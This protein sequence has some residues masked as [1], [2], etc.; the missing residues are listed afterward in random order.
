MK[1]IVFLL[2]L[3]AALSFTP[4]AYADTCLCVGGNGTS[5]SCGNGGVGAEFLKSYAISSDGYKGFLRDSTA[6][7]VYSRDGKAFDSKT[8][9]FCWKG[10]LP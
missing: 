7:A 9:W 2:T 3:L 8:G 6:Q 1:K 4:Q 10:N 5:K